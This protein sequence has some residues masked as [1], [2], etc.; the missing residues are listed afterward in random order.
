MV[1]FQVPT[2]NRFLEENQ[3]ELA[4]LATF[5]DF[6]VGLTIGFIEINNPRDVDT[7]M[8]ALRDRFDP[9]RVRFV[10]MDFSRDRDLRFLRDAMIERLPQVKLKS[11]EKLVLVIRG[12]EVAIGTD[13]VGD[14]PPVLQDLNFV[15]DAYAQTVA[16][17][18]LFVLPDYAIT[19]VAKYAPDF[20]AWQSGSFS[21]K[22]S[23]EQ[24]QVLQVEAFEKRLSGIASNEN[25]IQ[26]QQLIQLLMEYQPSGK[27]ID[28]ANVKTCSEIYY[29]LGSA[30]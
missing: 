16:Y 29:K 2:Q 25:E 19:R 20:W 18:L 12:L 23:P 9:K 4:E 5:V 30:Y 6:A 21:F 28:V 8:Q 13:S 27:P 15:R 1:K 26:I 14:Y 22:T 24:R 17:P 7:L 11:K 10:V 3:Q